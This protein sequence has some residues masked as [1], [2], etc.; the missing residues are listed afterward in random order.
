MST[1]PK[2]V[3]INSQ[4]A[5]SGYY[6]PA[7]THRTHRTHR[8]HLP[9]SQ[10]VNVITSES[11]FQSPESDF[12]SPE[13]DFQSPESDFQSPESDLP[14]AVSLPAPQLPYHFSAG[15]IFSHGPFTTMTSSCQCAAAS[16]RL[17]SRLAFHFHL[18]IS[19]V[20]VSVPVST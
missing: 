6:A 20:P 15:L 13:S 9:F 3:N 18:V 16:D 14:S 17:R 4:W 19:S 8:T 1:S 7:G 12:Q 10:N 11:D 2:N 5:Q